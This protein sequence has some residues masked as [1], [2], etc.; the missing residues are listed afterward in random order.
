MPKASKMGFSKGDIMDFEVFSVILNNS[1]VSSRI[2]MKI[3]RNYLIMKEKAVKSE[4]DWGSSPLPKATKI[5]FSHTEK[6]WLWGDV[7]V[8]W[9]NLWF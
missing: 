7:N 4:L 6:K 1:H 8:T 2:C 3:T 9:L 5:G